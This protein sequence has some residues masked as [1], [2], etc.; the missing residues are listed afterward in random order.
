[1]K[2]NRK[3]NMQKPEK[4]ELLEPL[5]K[6][7]LMD[8]L[9]KYRYIFRSVCSEVPGLE[10]GDECTKIILNMKGKNDGE[11]ERPLIDFL[12]YVENSSDA[13]ISGGCDERL[14]HLHT[15]VEKIK[16]NE[17]MGVTYMKMQERDRQIREDGR[18]EGEK[19][20]L[21]SQVQKKLEKGKT[22]DEIAEGLEEEISVIEELMKE[23]E[24]E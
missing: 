7:N 2:E 24:A 19:A 1:M 13:V 14:V 10:L 9:G 3:Q 12:H 22:A 18:E 20:K 6:M 5:R 4:N 16:A 23:L 21:L 17:Q 15:I 8:D 11:V